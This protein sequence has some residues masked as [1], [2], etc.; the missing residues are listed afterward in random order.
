VRGVKIFAVVV[1]AVV[2][3]AAGAAAVLL[4]TF[5]P[6]E[7]KGYVTRWAE[8]R[9]GRSLAIRDDLNLQ[10]FPS[11]AIETGGIEVGNAPGFGEEPFATI[12]RAAAEV[13]LWPLLSRRIEL[14][15][16]RVD[17]LRLSLATD[18]DGRGNWEDLLE[19]G[20]AGAEPRGE[21]RAGTAIA[22]W[23]DTLDVAGVRIRDSSVTLRDPG[24]MRYSIEDVTLSSGRLRAGEPVDVSA[25]FELRDLRARRSLGVDAHTS[26]TLAQSGVELRGT[27]AELRFSDDAHGRAA[28]GRLTAGVF[29]APAAGPLQLTDTR[30]DATVTG[31]TAGGEA[32]DVGAAWNAA[33]FDPETGTARIDGLSTHAGDIRADWRLEARDL[34]GAPRL[35]GTATIDAAPAAQVLE[36]LQLTPPAGVTPDQLG[37]FDLSAG[38]RASLAAPPP[39]AEGT[40]PATSPAPGTA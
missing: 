10:L 35:E 17:G 27:N 34:L 5:D 1:G 29:A 33:S 11:L 38:F 12:E 37:T 36:L 28:R 19:A 8:Q 26:A 24:A 7:Y 30:L 18:A 9:T 32:L 14:G 40:S 6:N 15:T 31:A 3:L 21:P 25:A 22:D 39:G 2:L 20:A 16:I 4:A 23:L 13:K